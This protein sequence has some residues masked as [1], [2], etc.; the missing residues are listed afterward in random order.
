MDTLV[1]GSRMRGRGRLALAAGVVLAVL[2][3]AGGPAEA[4]TGPAAELGITKARYGTLPSGTAIFQYTLTNSHGVRVKII[5]YGGIVTAIR[6][7]DR[8]GRL[9]NVALGLRNLHDY[10]TQNGGPFFGAIIG[11]YANR[12]ANGRFTLD[13]HTFHLPRNN[14]PNTL[15]GGPRG[16][17]KRVWSA[18]VVRG[19][20][21]VG[22][23]LHRVSADGEQGFPGRMPVTV[24]YRLTEG[25]ALRIHYR[26]TTSEPTVVNLTNH[27]Y[28]NL[29]GEGSGSILGERLMINAHRY[30][31]VDA[32]LIPTGVRAP[33]AGTPFDFT[34]PTAIGA[35]IHRDNPQLVIAHGYDHNFVLARPP[36]GSA[37]ALAARAIEPRSGRV[38]SVFTD[39]PG[40]QFYSGNFLDGSL[41][42]PS[43]HTYRQSDG[44]ALETQHF[45]NSPNEPSFP[46]TVL[47]PG[48]VYRTTTV[49]TFSTRR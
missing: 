3:L 13:G 27:T 35:R 8:E 19:P 47:R 41:V 37:L 26:A 21:S 4:A 43:G 45:P 14:G 38:L 12:I 11:R 49:F 30:T 6:V 17:D 44:F 9:R 22:L 39:Q 23:R 31:P 32:T 42:G 10:V 40:M 5:T 15:H 25:N 18:R 16:F 24:T 36:G 2:G 1:A 33:V 46:S 7:P 20:E 29:A 28:W 48:Q 34:R